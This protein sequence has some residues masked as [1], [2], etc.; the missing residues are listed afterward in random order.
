MIEVENVSISH[1]ICCAMHSPELNGGCWQVP[2]VIVQLTQ[3]IPTHTRHK[4]V[5]ST[6]TITYNV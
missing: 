6:G 3:L 4:V 2:A 5:N 1:A